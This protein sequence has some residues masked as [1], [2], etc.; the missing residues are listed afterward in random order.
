VK[1]NSAIQALKQ[2]A[3]GV[4]RTPSIPLYFAGARSVSSRYGFSVDSFRAAATR[5]AWFAAL[6]LVL[7]GAD[8]AGLPAGAVAVVAATWTSLKLLPAGA[9]RLAP[10]ALL[11]PLAR[12]LHQS[13]VAGADVAWRALDPRLP[14]RPGFVTCP[15]RVAPGAARSAVCTV[16]SLLPGTLP[17]GL[18][19][20][21]ALL[22]H[23][24]D[25]DQ[26]VAAQFTEDE[27]M[28][29]TAVG[30]AQDYG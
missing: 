22:I 13:V 12:F 26:P 2:A 9:W 21:G 19:E 25:T 4:W 16:A 24:L 29:M 3:L 5:A 6:W 11:R 8:P 23:C 28:L 20:R 17:A 15:V 18:D 7:S 27:A 1:P 14:L 10:G 30:A